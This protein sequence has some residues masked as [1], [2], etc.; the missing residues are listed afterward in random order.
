MTDLIYRHGT[1]E[2]ASDDADVLRVVMANEGRMGDGLDL[3]MDGADLKRFKANPVLGFGHNYWGRDSLPIGRVENAAVDGKRLVGDVVFDQGD[4]F[5][6]SV[7][8]KL[9]DGFL[10]AFSIGFDPRAIDDDGVVSDWELFELSVVPIPMDPGA[11]VA[12]GRAAAKAL[13]TDLLT[14]VDR[15]DAGTGTINTDLHR[16]TERIDTGRLTE[17][18]SGGAGGTDTPTTPH[19]ARHRVL[20]LLGVIP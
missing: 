18:V 15:L 17:S 13:R 14:L 11:L 19:L 8:R 10:S 3:R 4:E 6:V 1:I 12:A 5:A 20:Q 2:R 9:R 7:E 16:L